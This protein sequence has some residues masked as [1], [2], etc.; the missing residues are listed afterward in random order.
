MLKKSRNVNSR[1]RGSPEKLPEP[2]EKASGLYDTIRQIF[3]LVRARWGRLAAG[4][5]VVLLVS[6]LLWWAWP[7]IKERPGVEQIVEWLEQLTPIPT[8]DERNFC[9]A[10]AELGQD[11]TDRF[12]SAIVDQLENLQGMVT[13]HE[14][15]GEALEPNIGIEVIRI[16]RTITT[17]GNKTRAAETAAD[18]KARRYLEKS[19]ADLIIWGTLVRVGDESGPRIFWTTSKE[20]Q[21][22]LKLLVFQ[23]LELPEEFF[24]KLTNLLKLVVL[25]QYSEIS[26]QQGRDVTGELAPL[27]EKVRAL[28]PETR[29]AGWTD[30]SRFQVKSLLA[31]SLVAYGDEVDNKA[32]LEEALGYY[33]ELLQTQ[34]RSRVPINWALTKSN[35]AVAL[36]LLG[37]RETG[38]EH[39]TDSVAACNA[40]LEEFTQAR[41]PHEWAVT[42]N[43]LGTALWILGERESGT[44]NLT[45]AVAAFRAALE[46]FTQARHPLEW[47]MTQNNLGN[48]FCALGERESGTQHLGD[49]VAAYRATLKEYTQA[50]VPLDWASTQNN[51]ATVLGDLGQREPGTQS[52]TDAV[53]AFRAALEEYTHT[54]FPLKWA[55]VQ[56]NLGSALWILGSRETGIQHLTEAVAAFI[57]ALEEFTQA[58]FPFQSAMTQNNLGS[59]LQDLGRRTHDLRTLCQAL[60]DHISAWRVF[61]QAAPSYASRAL[62]G[63][64]K[65]FQ[66][67]REQSP[68]TAAS[69]LQ[70]YAANLNHM[71]PN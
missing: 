20:T 46:V 22:S 34:S 60:G 54:R 30:D 14:S 42:Q 3:I 47:A 32:A 44:D 17:S 41:F 10:V 63:A 16:P 39:L 28:I 15:A 64:K 19:H 8:C 48:V 61:S 71:A 33:K 27:I 1:P 59:A 37:D 57:A 49:A 12:G 40:A 51:L 43:D 38:T 36:R 62:F 68:E 13:G 4:V 29:G 66:A 70:T 50:R 58:R 11:S 18:E 6:G 53:K 65:A 45:A 52:L 9:V 5:A 56:N 7:D 31:M 23:G 67:M 25:T 69:C 21:R 24:A 26:A 2:L 35:L 55:K